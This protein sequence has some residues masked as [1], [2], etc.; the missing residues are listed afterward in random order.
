MICQKIIPEDALQI[1]SV[2]SDV[3]ETQVAFS[4]EQLFVGEEPYLASSQRR[5]L[6]HDDRVL[7]QELG[8]RLE[9]P[10]E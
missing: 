8:P 2:D 10:A 4:R 7:V 3:D 5:D 6:S 9:D 1:R